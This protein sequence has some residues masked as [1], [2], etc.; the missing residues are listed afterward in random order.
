MD[1]GYPRDISVWTA[2][3]SAAHK[4]QLSEGI[5]A[6]FQYSNS[7]TYFF[8]GANYYRFNDVEFTVSLI[9]DSLGV[10]A[11]SIA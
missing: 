10:G 5:D 4:Q 1:Q 7:R 6:A 3:S 11:Y 2:Y 8:V 9:F